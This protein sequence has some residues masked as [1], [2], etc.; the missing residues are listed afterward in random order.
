MWKQ[1]SIAP[2]TYTQKML[3]ATI[4][5]LADVRYRGSCADDGQR[6]TRNSL[7]RR[8]GECV[9]WHRGSRAPRARW[10]QGSDAAAH[11]ADRAANRLYAESGGASS[12]RNEIERAHRR[13]HAA[14]NPF[15]LRSAVERSAGRGEARRAAR[16]SVR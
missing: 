6:T 10:N 15:L 3:Y 8:N 11:P 16:H 13:L 4:A 7:D 1:R 9:D 14:R 5:P 2:L 12:L